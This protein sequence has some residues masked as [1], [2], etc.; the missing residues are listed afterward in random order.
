MIEST[1]TN[2]LKMKLTDEQIFGLWGQT[3]PY[4]EA[5]IVIQTRIMDDKVSRVFVEVQAKINPTTFKVVKANRHHFADDI[6]IQQLLDHSRDTGAKE[7]GYLTNA[8]MAEYIDES[9]MKEAKRRL[10]Y[11]KKSIIKMHKYTMELLDLKGH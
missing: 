8:F 11:V 6:P 7:F 1:H 4:S 9:V 5:E 3:G 2:L 10:E